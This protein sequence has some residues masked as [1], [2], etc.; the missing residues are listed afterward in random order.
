MPSLPNVTIL[1]AMDHANLWR[2]WFKHPETWAPWRAF[3]AVLFGLSLTE[4]ELALYAECTGR[5]EPP[6][7]QG[8]TEAWLV[9]GRRAGK[10][11]ILALIA[12]YLAIF[13][14]WK[15]Y[16]SPGEVGTVKIMATDRRQARVIHR[17]CRALLTKVPALAELVA[18]DSDESIELTCGIVIEIQTASFRSVRGF[19]V[20]AVLADEIAYWRSD[21]SSS[22]PD[23]E[24]IAAI[25]PAMATIPN[26]MFLAASSPYARRGELWLAHQRNHGHDTNALCWQA[27]TRVMNPTVPQR[28]IDE[29]LEEDA[30]KAA[31]EFL[32]QF[33]SDI[34]SFLDIETVQ[35]AV[36]RGVTVRHPTSR[37]QYTMAIDA[38]GGRRDS[39]T[40][41]VGHREDDMLIVDHAFERRAPFDPE[42]AYD[43]VT[44]LAE[45]YRIDTVRGD[46]YGG[47][48]IP[49]ALKKRGIRMRPIEIII[50]GNTVNL[51]RSKI[52]L[53]SLPLFT[54]GRVRLLDHPRLIHQLVGLERTTARSSGHDQV[55]HAPGA[56]DDVA[57]SVCACLVLL[58]AAAGSGSWFKH[59]TPGVLERARFGYHSAPSA[60]TNATPTPQDDRAERYRKAAARA[61]RMGPAW[62]MFG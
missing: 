1:E 47:D 29:A 15:P 43:E 4:A 5:K 19:T 33:R 52:Y 30:P 21:E 38:S 50:Q 17:Y 61:R 31:A 58:A 27:P 16:L 34:E 37:L 39:F 60:N 24:I 12:C 6:P 45:T 41:C 28:I 44:E 13:R 18:N 22:N 3:L 53:N 23:S 7:Q 51:D 10:S 36:D 59:I 42:D 14:D 9:C 25:R 55:N 32:A 57:N 62:K 2:P 40:A 20:I 48:L 26:A 8:F 56:H 49:S 46:A 11:F 35:A 54:S